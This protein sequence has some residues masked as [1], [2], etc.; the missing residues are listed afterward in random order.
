MTAGVV[1]YE[2]TPGPW[3]SQQ[4]S[5]PCRAVGIATGNGMIEGLVESPGM[6]ARDDAMRTNA[7]LQMRLHQPVLGGRWDGLSFVDVLVGCSVV[8]M[9]IFIVACS[10][11]TVR[12][13]ARRNNCANN[14]RR[15]SMAMN[16]YIDANGILPPGAVWAFD[17][18]ALSTLFS[19]ERPTPVELTRENWVQL[20]LPH[21]GEMEL[22]RRFEPASS[23]VDDANATARSA[24]LAIMKCPSDPYNRSDNPYRIYRPGREAMEFSRG[25]YAINGGS[26]HIPASFGTLANPGPTLTRTVYSE[27]RREF[28]WWGNGIVGINKCFRLK[29]IRNG[30]ATTVGIEE[31]RAGLADID[32]RGVWSLGQIGGSMTWGHGVVG[33]AGGPNY[34]SKDEAADDILGGPELHQQLGKAFID[35][36]RMYCCDHCN[37]NF[38]ATA[39]SK[40]PGGVQVVM[41]DGA[42]RFVADHIDPTVWHL[43][44]S[45]ETPKDVLQGGLDNELNGG[46]WGEARGADLTAQKRDARQI[47]SKEITNSIGMT[48][49]WIPPGELLMGLPN[50]GHDMPFPS[51]A[52][53]HRVRI[54]RS[55]Y[56]GR[57]EVTQR[58]FRSV[59]GW[60][61]SWHA[62]TGAGHENGPA[63]TS[64]YPVENV[65][66]AEAAEF[67][68]RLSSLTQEGVAG[69][70]YRLPTEAE[71]EYACRAGAVEPI[72]LYDPLRPI[73][74]TGEIGSKGKEVPLFQTTV[75]VASYPANHFGICDMCGNVYE[76]V[77]DYRR[78]GYYGRSPLED[79]Q[80]PS[81]GYFRVI[82]GWHW[83]ATGPRCKV[84]VA[85]EPW[86]G[87]RFIGFRVAMDVCSVG[88]LE[89]AGDVQ[90][91]RAADKRNDFS[92]HN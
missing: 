8:S 49:V 9:F 27:N 72:P 3:V 55:Y 75:P 48:L 24:E 21:L 6:V 40:H 15:L 2:F 79:P 88:Q 31:I 5:I 22:A 63:D 38:Q 58:D 68:E 19:H 35:G 4:R 26:E 67:C 34:G 44:H 89:P 18:T 10:L 92:D 23:I 36:E 50:K 65:T 1:S 70:S 59:M 33:D 74:K 25:N 42:V 78:R 7:R 43:I 57:C 11:P 54:T 46:V 16:S 56:L 81:T 47:M 45:R 64:S 32:P 29:D 14:L 60:N 85:Q 80:G 69:R 62:P 91:V 66:W 20:L 73:A 17:K 12:E 82:R 28:Q 53:T 76:W 77:H 61:P 37:E 52:I 86:T 90:G 71:W 84:Y 41:L 87:S 13:M 51:D 39:R 30:A 83:V